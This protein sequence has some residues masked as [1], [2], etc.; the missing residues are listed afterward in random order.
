MI[1]EMYRVAGMNQ[2][3][4]EIVPAFQVITDEGGV[5]LARADLHPMTYG[6]IRRHLALIER[7]LASTDPENENVEDAEVVADD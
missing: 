3:T 2:E 7:L 4:G 6:A 5:A 1:V